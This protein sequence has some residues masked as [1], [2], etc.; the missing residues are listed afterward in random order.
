MNRTRDT[1][2]PP[3]LLFERGSHFSLPSKIWR[4][5][6]DGFWLIWTRVVATLW[7]RLSVTS[8]SF[9]PKS[10]GNW[11]NENSTNPSTDFS[12][13]FQPWHIDISHTH[14]SSPFYIFSFSSFRDGAQ[15]K[16]NNNKTLYQPL[17]VSLNQFCWADSSISTGRLMCY[18]VINVRDLR[19]HIKD[20]AT[21]F[22]PSS[23]L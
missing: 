6:F 18:S 10:N 1:L 11:T 17:Y 3:S 12:V 16:R 7:T 20:A 21:I 2:N 22:Q 5:F 13:I 19:A 15:A 4:H 8:L 14:I 9:P 23:G